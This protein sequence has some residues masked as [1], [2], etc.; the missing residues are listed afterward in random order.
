M[1]DLELLLPRVLEK[2]PACPEPTALRHLR[3][4]AIEFC[5]RTRVWR[6]DD[7][8][9]L[10]E[11]G[12]EAVAVEAGTVLFEISH[13]AYSAAVEEG[14]EASQIPLEP[15]TMDWLDNE[16]PNWRTEEGTPA[17]ITQTAPN[18]VRI[19]P[20]PEVDEDDEDAEPGTLS[21][22]LILVPSE[23]AEQLPDVL[24][25]TYS[26]EIADGAIASILLLKTE[27]ADTELALVHEGKFER[28]LGRWGNRIQRGQQRAPRRNRPSPNY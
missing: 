26:R 17:Y 8:F 6:N 15:V 24:I 12:C 16:L 5:R 3:D 13:A 25:D 4:A 19:V 11:N 10:G 20:K 1:K 2:A 21:L 7:E 27:F 14:D 22:Q 18:T 23:D 9:T 28:S